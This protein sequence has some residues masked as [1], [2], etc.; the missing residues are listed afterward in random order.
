MTTRN[1]TDA[2]VVRMLGWEFRP[3]NSTLDPHPVW[4]L[5]NGN[6]IDPSDLPSFGLSTPP[7]PEADANAA[8]YVL[9]WVWEQWGEIDLKLRPGYVEVVISED[10][11]DNPRE[12]TGNDISP[13]L[14]TAALE[15]WADLHPEFFSPSP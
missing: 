1:W 3:Y 14:C 7:S 11:G 5:P 12:F 9:P 6:V 13:T 2:D 4:K 10:L 15:A 8:R